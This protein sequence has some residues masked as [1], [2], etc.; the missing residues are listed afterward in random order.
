MAALQ[1]PDVVL[2]IDHWPAHGIPR[3]R[4]L[5]VHGLGEHPGRYEALAAQLVRWGLDVRAVHLR[6]HGRAGGARGDAPSATA[7]LEDVAAAIDAVREPGCPFILLG[8]SLGG[9]LVAR[10]AAAALRGE[11]FGREP[12]WLVLSSPAL[13]PGMRWHQHLLLALGRRFLP[14]LG[15][16]NGLKPAWISRDPAVVKLYQQDPMVHGRV[17]PTVAQMVVDAGAAVQGEAPRW[18][19]P[20]LLL[21]AGADRCVAPRGSRALAE[22][23]PPGV[24]QA[25]CFD[26]LAHEIFNEP[27][28]AEVLA[29]LKAALDHRFAELTSR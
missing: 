22:A 23:A 17:T 11:P 13:D 10:V 6:G 12:D 24:L 26:N 25:R 14:H 2:P 21:W 5:I 8:H 15:A 4:V 1:R 27:E 18:R 9:L 3:A 28:R 16:S 19:V 7:M 29:V 20:T